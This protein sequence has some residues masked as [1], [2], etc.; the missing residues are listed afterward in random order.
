MKTSSN[1]GARMRRTIHAALLICTAALLI[2]SPLA[3]TLHAQESISGEVF[4]ILAS[5]EAGPVDPSLAQIPALSKPPFN[6]FRSMQVLTRSTVS[7]NLGKPIDLALPNNRRMSITLREK[8]P[9]GRSKVQVSIKRPN[10]KD[11]LPLLE[12]IASPNEPFFVAG[13]KYQKGTLVIGV[14]IGK[15]TGPSR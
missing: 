11:Y 5:E 15:R 13:Q 14:R 12:V 9:D 7:L 1:M 2:H 6:G 3:S 4:V 10:E 8:M